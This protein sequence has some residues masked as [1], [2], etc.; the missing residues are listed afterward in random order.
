MAIAKAKLT[1]EEFMRL[2]DDGRKY[3]LV[4]GEAKEVPAGFQHAAI[5]ANIIALF[6]PYA[7]GRDIL[8]AS[9][10]G[11]RMV[12]GN[13]RSPDVSFTLKSRLPQGR[14]NKGFGNLA[15]DLCIEIISD[16]ED[17]ADMER[18]VGEYFTAGAQQV[19]HLFPETQTA[20]VFTAPAAFTDY[21]PTDTLDG[22]DLLPGFR[23]RVAELFALE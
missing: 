2:P 5:V 11:F 6:M 1:E 21:A 3:E 18:K 7:R 22:G 10:A 12:D 20:R 23:C 17:R 14:P 9:Q 15:P 8:A 19:W 16:S 4:D 13:I